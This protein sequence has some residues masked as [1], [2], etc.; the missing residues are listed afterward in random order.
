[1]NTTLL[2]VPPLC[3]P[4]HVNLREVVLAGMLPSCHLGLHPASREEKVKAC[5]SYV[6]VGVGV[7]VSVGVGVGDAI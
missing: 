7:G 4:E 2:N 3:S 5:G 6:G 1:M